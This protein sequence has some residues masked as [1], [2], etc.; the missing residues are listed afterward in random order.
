MIK[1]IKKLESDLS[2]I[3]ECPPL[4]AIKYIR[5]AIGYEKCLK[6]YAAE[7]KL[8]FSEFKSILSLLESTAADFKTNKQWLAFI[9]DCSCNDQSAADRTSKAIKKGVHIMTMHA[10]KGLEFDTVFIPQLN[11]GFIPH[12]KALTASEIEE[13]RRLLY[14]AMTRAK[15]KLII[16]YDKSIN[17][18][19]ALPSPF[20]EEILPI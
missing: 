11:A 16:S 6:E 19:T 10:C 2:F 18:K 4:A 1:R 20:W 13:E 7:K 5:H 15:N 8:D 12:A 3:A 14:V 9:N 17:E